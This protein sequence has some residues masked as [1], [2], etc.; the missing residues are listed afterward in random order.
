MKTIKKLIPGI[1]LALITVAMYHCLLNGAPCQGDGRMFYMVLMGI[2]CLLVWLAATGT[3]WY[4]KWL[5]RK[6][7]EYEEMVDTLLKIMDELDK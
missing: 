4:V 5:R 2:F 6:K 7:T 1:A 3:V